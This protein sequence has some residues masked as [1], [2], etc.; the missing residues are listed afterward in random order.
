MCLTGEWKCHSRWIT[1]R[2]LI[3]FYTPPA[4]LSTMRD[5]QV[6]IMMCHT[7]QGFAKY[8]PRSVFAY[9]TFFL[10][11]FHTW[12]G[13]FRKPMNWPLSFKMKYRGRQVRMCSAKKNTK[14][15]QK[16]FFGKIM[17][18][19]EVFSL[20]WSYFDFRTKITHIKFSTI[21]TVIKRNKKARQKYVT[22]TS[23]LAMRQVLFLDVHKK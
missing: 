4:W 21:I 8:L 14:N 17:A 10:S 19:K 7:F 16:I 13:L 11:T 6:V 1:N 15:K 23:I 12:L 9:K 3:S 2:R 20:L 5:T 22:V 18:D